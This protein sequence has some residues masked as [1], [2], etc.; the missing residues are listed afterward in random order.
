MINTVFNQ[1]PLS[2]AIRKGYSNCVST[3][4]FSLDK[5]L[6]IH[7][8]SLK[9]LSNDTLVKLNSS[10]C[11]SLLKFYD[12]IFRKDTSEHAAKFCSNSA[13]IPIHFW[14][15]NIFIENS[16]FL[17]S[18]ALKEQERPI[19][20]LS[21]YVMLDLTV[22]SQASIDFLFSIYDSPNPNIMMTPIIQEIIRYK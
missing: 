3:I 7:P 17:D 18:K 5:Y 9:S 13:E 16:N 10:N 4:I 14:S 21:S 20:F 12:A 2:I 6:P 1:N 8:Y 19:T 22:G 15:E 11:S